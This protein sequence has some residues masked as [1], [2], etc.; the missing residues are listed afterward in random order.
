ML[1]CKTQISIDNG[2]LSDPMSAV[3]RL[4]DSVMVW[5]SGVMAMFR[6][7]NIVVKG[8]VYIARMGSNYVGHN[9]PASDGH[10]A[11]PLSTAFVDIIVPWQPE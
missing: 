10:A 7:F 6:R 2:I 4:P 8:V 3:A 5:H 11:S 9:W 1:F